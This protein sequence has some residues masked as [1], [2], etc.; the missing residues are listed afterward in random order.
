MPAKIANIRTRHL[1]PKNWDCFAKL[2]GPFNG[3][4][5]GE[6]LQTNGVVD[7]SK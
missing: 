1:V 6:Q 2:I 3:G 4:G 5:S 7:Y